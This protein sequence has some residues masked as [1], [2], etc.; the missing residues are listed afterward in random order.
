MKRKNSIKT[1]YDKLI[2]DGHVEEERLSYILDAQDKNI[3]YYKK[4]E[5]NQTSLETTTTEITSFITSLK[6]AIMEERVYFV[7]FDGAKLKIKYGRFYQ[8]YEYEFTLTK[9]AKNNPLISSFLKKLPEIQPNYDEL[10]KAHKYAQPLADTYYKEKPLTFENQSDLDGFKQFLKEKK[11]LLSTGKYKR[12]QKRIDKLTSFFFN[13]LFLTALS[14]IFYL[15]NTYSELTLFLKILM[16]VGILF[17]KDYAVKD[18]FKRIAVSSVS[19]Q[20]SLAI[21]ENQELLDTLSLD[22]RKKQT[23]LDDHSHSKDD[24][25]EKVKRNMERVNEAQYIGYEEHLNRLYALALNYIKIKKQKGVDDNLSTQK[26]IILTTLSAIESEIEESLSNRALRSPKEEML[27]EEPILT[28]QEERET[29]PFS[30]TESAQ[31]PSNG[32]LT[33]KL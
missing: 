13:Y 10:V 22:Q 12:Y 23:P 21:Q 15:S 4:P 2:V 26:S 16:N 9:E 24:I 7:Y 19:R 25:I 5:D 29:K 30:L 6:T 28:L 11:R 31:L 1:S 14:P 20:V 3:I 17:L 27:L 33:L 32:S 8:F 18:I